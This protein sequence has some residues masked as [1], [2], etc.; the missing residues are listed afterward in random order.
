MKKTETLYLKYRPSNFSEVLGQDEVVSILKNSLKNRNFSH[1]YLFSGTHGTGKTSIARIFAKEL[2]SSDD[3]IYEIDAA[4]NRG[5]NEI[6]EIRDSVEVLPISSE[7]K[8]YII[9]EAHM[10][11]KEAS[12]ALL[13]TL[14]EPPKHVI[15]ILATTEKHKVLPTIVSRCQAFEFN[16]PENKKLEEL[17]LNISKK[18]KIKIDNESVSFLARLGDRSFRNTLSNLQK[19]FS[20]FNKEIK[21]E[22]LKEIFSDSSEFLENNFL[23]ALELNNKEKLLEEYFNISEKNYDLNLFLEKIIEKIRKSLL[24]KNS[25][26]FYQKFNSEL[27]KDE[28]KFLNNLNIGSKFL[29]DFLILA[30][31]IKLSNNPKIFFEIFLQDI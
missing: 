16:S 9:D 13:K 12:N 19:A 27:S 8:I 20:V 29:R 6:R 21:I 15:F 10:L 18:E 17:I 24:I 5:I 14:E 31:D 11:T 7:F 23:K 4:S 26:V 2:K 28:F 1:A 25:K 30:D 3:D 22:E